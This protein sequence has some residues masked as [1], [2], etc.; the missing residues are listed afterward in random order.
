M[1]IK[2]VRFARPTANDFYST[3]KLRVHEY[4]KENN[5]S[6]HA[7]G[8][9]V[10]KTVFMIAL[11]LV[12]YT[13]MLTLGL[14]NVWVMMLIWVIMGFGM[15]GIGLSIMHDANHGAY[16]DNPTVNKILGALIILV[17]GDDNNWKIQHNVLHH[18]YTNIHDLDEDIQTAPILR[19]SPNEKLRPIHR[20]QFVYAWFFYGMMTMF[21]STFK[22]FLQMTRYN[23]K[24]LTKSIK[25]GFGTL[26][27][28]MV[29]SKVFYYIITLVIPLIVL[30]FAW[31]QIVLGYLLMHFVAGFSLACIF[32][33]AHV[34]P[35]S[36]FLNPDENETIETPWAEHQLRTTSN[37]APKKRIFSWF[38]GGLNYQIEHHLFPTICH[39][40]YREISEIVK[41]TAHEFNLPYNSFSTFRSA[42]KYHGQM[43]YRLGR[44]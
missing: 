24:G 23:R 21:W 1:D 32:Q 31:W 25:K 9:M 36:D 26:M 38:V 28:R 2:K 29:L 14:T 4:F 5:I 3:V 17:G 40:H 27:T 37:F 18:T 42:L 19:F 22:D 35:E 13:L 8:R 34:L 6:K 39:V 7:D 10:F 11:Y 15:S 20:L 43:L 44:Q 12:P 41:K 16:S 33:P 30:P